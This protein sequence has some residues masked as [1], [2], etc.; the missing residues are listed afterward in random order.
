M[1]QLSEKNMD[2]KKY[3]LEN[4]DILKNYC[5]KTGISLK[6]VLSSP[7]GHNK[8]W[9]VVQ[10]VDYNSEKSKLGL[11]DSIPAKVLLTIRR[12][13]DGITF[14]PSPDIKNYLA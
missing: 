13:S 3:L 4:I 6:K 14:E 7:C 1:R 11:K 12:T 9:I 5:D 8:E 10:Y 2:L